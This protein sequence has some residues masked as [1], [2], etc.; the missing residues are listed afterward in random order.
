M[1]MVMRKKQR[2]F[3]E[4][5]GARIQT[6]DLLIEGVS[7]DDVTGTPQT[8]QNGYESRNVGHGF[9]AVGVRGLARGQL[10]GVKIVQLGGD[11]VAFEAMIMDR[12]QELEYVGNR[13][14]GSSAVVA[15]PTEYAAGYGFPYGGPDAYGESGGYGT[16]AD[17]T[18]NVIEADA[19]AIDFENRT[20]FDDEMHEIYVKVKVGGVST[21]NKFHVKLTIVPMA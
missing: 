17:V 13:I 15:T 21:N 12:F 3:I 19:L 2:E 18:L 7:T 14:W 5:P 11:A 16:P 8:L 9:V 4:N 20:S 6:V 10:S 1:N